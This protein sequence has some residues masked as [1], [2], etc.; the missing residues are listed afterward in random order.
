MSI[1]RTQKIDPKL[2][3]YITFLPEKAL[4]LEEARAADQAMGRGD[5]RGPLHE[6]WTVDEERRYLQALSPREAMHVRR[7]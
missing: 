3:S 2:N 1:D 4:A 6:V 5:Y 7:R